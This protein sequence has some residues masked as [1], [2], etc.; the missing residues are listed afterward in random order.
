MNLWR[1][2]ASTGEEGMSNHTPTEH[3]TISSVKSFH[4][5]LGGFET[6]TFPAPSSIC[7]WSILVENLP[8]G[9]GDTGKKKVDGSVFWECFILGEKEKMLCFGNHR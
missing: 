8:R 9:R 5:S 1:P 6:H 2:L 3:D 4:S 7:R